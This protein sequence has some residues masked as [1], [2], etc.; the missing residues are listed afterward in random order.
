[1]IPL[2]A[3]VVDSGAQV[4]QLAPDAGAADLARG[5]AGLLRLGRLPRLGRP[6][7]PVRAASLAR[8]VLQRL[9]GPPFTELGDAL[10]RLI[11]TLLLGND[12]VGIDRT[13]LLIEAITSRTRNPSGGA[14]ASP[15]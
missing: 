13:G 14:A 8:H 3:V 5:I 12:L 10:R 15:A 9:A 7:I 4:L 1:V 2:F 6:E 11:R